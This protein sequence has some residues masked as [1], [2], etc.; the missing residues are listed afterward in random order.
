MDVV[1]GSSD[2]TTTLSKAAK[3][4]SVSID[5]RYVAIGDAG[6]TVYDIGEVIGT[7]KSFRKAS[8]PIP[9]EVHLRHYSRVHTD[10]PYVINMDTNLFAR[11]CDV[12]SKAR[13]VLFLNSVAP[14]SSTTRMSRRDE[15]MTVLKAM[16]SKRLS[17]QA[18]TNDLKKAIDD[19]DALRNEILDLL[20]RQDLI[21]DVQS[22]TYEQL[23]GY[24][25]LSL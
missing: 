1:E 19:L 24:A 11:L 10:V 17:F 14:G 7:F 12:F 8:K 4:N 6:N 9:F 23:K 22:L 20:A 2:F 5:V 13:F 16:R 15:L 3:T 21:V 25:V 18:N